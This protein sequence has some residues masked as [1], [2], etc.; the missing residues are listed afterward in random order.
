MPS[1]AG[2]RQSFR[3]CLASRGRCSCH[4][5]SVPIRGGAVL[6]GQQQQ[7]KHIRSLDA[8]RP[9]CGV[10]RLIRCQSGVTAS[11]YK[12]RPAAALRFAPSVI[13][14]PGAS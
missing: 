5:P 9:L 2:R 14:Q 6:T 8:L 10:Q 4:L 7:V 13:L 11:L 12:H 3:W 1:S